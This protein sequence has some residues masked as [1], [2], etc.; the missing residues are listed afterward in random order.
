MQKPVLSNKLFED[1]RTLILVR[2][3]LVEV[4]KNSQKLIDIIVS[5]FSQSGIRDINDFYWELEQDENLTGPCWAYILNQVTVPESFFFRDEGQLNLLKSIIIPKILEN[6][7]IS[8]KIRIWS[9][10]CSRGEEVYTLAIIL[11]DLIP[12]NGKW[13]IK[14]IGTDL[15]SASIEKAKAGIYSQWSLRTLGNTKTDL[16]F[17]KV[18]NGFR[19][20]DEYRRIVDFLTFNLVQ[21]GSKYPEP[22]SGFDLIICRNVFIYFNQNIV[23]EIVAK[24]SQ[25]LNPKGYAIFGHAE[26][27]HENNKYFTPHYFPQSVVYQKTDPPQSKPALPKTIHRH[28]HLKP[29]AADLSERI[30]LLRTNLHSAGTL[31]T[32]DE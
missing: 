24:M 26:Y 19:V 31:R 27:V 32:N 28:E 20:R 13:D 30:S 9:A 18:K 1:I 17:T 21:R 2:T 22:I 16:W 3:G 15:N 12:D 4:L 14:I 5:C 10:G 6:V 11:K 7:K 29:V 23:Q 8:G 25:A